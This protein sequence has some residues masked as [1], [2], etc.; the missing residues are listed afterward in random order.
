MSR[1]QGRP[2]ASGVGWRQLLWVL[3]AAPGIASLVLLVPLGMPLLWLEAP[4]AGTVVGPEGFE[5]MVRFAGRV[6]PETFRVL[7]N[8]ADVTEGFTT[9]ENGSVGRLHGLLDGENLVRAEVFGHS[10]LV[11]W[12]LVEESDEVSV[13]HRRPLDLDR[14]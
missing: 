8:G 5:V 6:A 2:R 12:L 1:A 9:G 10:R 11:P 3:V 13:V 7:L 14:G 4:P